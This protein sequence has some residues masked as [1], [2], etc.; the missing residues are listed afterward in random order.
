[1]KINNLEVFLE[2]A[3][4]GKLPLGCCVTF[5]DPA[6]TEV[7]CASGFDFVWI[8]GEETFGVANVDATR[9]DIGFDAAKDIGFMDVPTGTRT[10]GPGEFAMFFP[11]KGAHAPCKS[12]TGK[13]RIR[14]VVIKV[15]RDR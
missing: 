2:K 9:A 4:G 10:I 3:R 7:A 11:G 5:S 13:R 15:L 12:L 6:V 14:K 8:D 1:M